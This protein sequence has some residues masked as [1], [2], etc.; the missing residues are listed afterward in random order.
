VTGCAS[1]TVREIIGPK[2]LLQAGAAIPIFALTVRGK[3]VIA[4][5]IVES[6]ATIFLKGEKLPVIGPGQPGPLI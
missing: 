2:A 1:K 3:E 5:R 6:T 4:R